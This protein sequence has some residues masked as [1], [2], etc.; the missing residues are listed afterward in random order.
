MA[1]ADWLAATDVSDRAAFVGN[2]VGLLSDGARRKALGAA[3]KAHYDEAYS[4]EVMVR[5]LA[6]RIREAGISEP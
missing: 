1:K 5:T 3:G 4:W 2:V 6:A